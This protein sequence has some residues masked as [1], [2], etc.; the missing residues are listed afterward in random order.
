M[1][2]RV[3]SAPPLTVKNPVRGM[4]WLALGAISILALGLGLHALNVRDLWLDEGLSAGM[5]Q[6]SWSDF[7]K[8]LWRRDANMG[9]YFLLLRFWSV[10]GD[11][12]VV[13]RMLSVGFSVA[14][15]L[16]IGALGRMLFGAQAGFI[17]AVL[18]AL[19]AF[20]L[21]YAQELR[22]YGLLILLVT[23]ATYFF[24]RMMLDDPSTRNRRLYLLTST[25]A[26]YTHF[27]SV[28]VTAAHF[29]VLALS[30]RER[31]R[32]EPFAKT[33]RWIAV[34]CA[35]GIL[36]LLL[37]NRGQLDWISPPTL[38]SFY[39]FLLVF[40]GQGGPWLLLAYVGAC[41][42]ALAFLRRPKASMPARELLAYRL[43]IAWLVL[44]IVA[45]LLVSAIKPIFVSRYLTMSL[46][47]LVLLASAGLQRL[48]PLARVVGVT[49][50]VVL[51]SLGVRNYY[52]GLPGEGEQWRELTSFVVKNSLARDRLIL[53]NGIARPVFEYYRRSAV[54]PEV[55]FPRHGSR[56]TYRDFEGIATPKL[57]AS[58]KETDGRVWLIAR[59]ADR[60]LEQA[61]AERFHLSEQRNFRGARVLLYVRSAS[62]RF[63]ASVPETTPG[64]GR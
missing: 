31:L 50:L 53:D 34:I 14:S 6:L 54:W 18:L 23:L 48:R 15:V 30:D 58:M 11:S 64:I 55:I 8:L 33:A 44:P 62:P 60:G 57:V 52:A 46:P 59:D 13:L 20:H 10:L 39:Q 43:T 12:E 32:S 1:I 21:R 3:A 38:D 28:L 17:A 19:N 4:Y 2:S 37:R 42:I 47:A 63:P 51:A 61:M 29:I 27:F 40:T 26:F 16:A 25:L 56:I 22:G 9:F 36:F 49:G 45:L 35:P 41:T 7:F 5:A 24:V